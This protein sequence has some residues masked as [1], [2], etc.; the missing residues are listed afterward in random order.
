[1][2]AKII[3]TGSY[4]PENRV[5][6]D[7]LS[8]I[9]DTS[10]EWISSKTGIRER[11]V[12]L[13]EG[14]TDMAVKAAKAALENGNVESKDIDLIVC[15]TCS[16]DKFLPSTACEVQAAIGA[17]NATA[18]DL[19]AA[20]SGF[21]FGLNTAAA[22][23]SSGLAKTALIIG[24]ETLS[25]LMDWEDRSCCVLFGDG[26]GAAIVTASDTNGI[27][28]TITGSDGSRGS[29]LECSARKVSNI[30]VKNQ[31]KSDYVSMDGRSV[32]QFAVTTVPEAILQLLEKTET[33]KE[34]IT[35]FLLHQANK[36]IITS[37][38]KRLKTDIKKF[39]TDMEFYGNTSAASIPILLD[40]MNRQG[41]LSHGDKIV[42]AGFGGGL[43]WAATLIE[44]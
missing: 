1:M 38:A 16:P 34:D 5:T 23:I 10:D 41:K 3:G 12:S 33:A 2:L 37:V 15:A 17:L 32:Y 13:G 21:M 36:R 14:T 19:S 28:D 22:Y 8:T 4:L 7:Y 42:I 26:A 31:E 24:A 30:F 18:F 39:P 29:A 6:N 43:T 27:V 35:Y 11:R 25:K 44:W 20:C 40:E 9:M